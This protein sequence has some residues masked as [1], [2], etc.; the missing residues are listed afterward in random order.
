MAK[1]RDSAAG[2]GGH[3]FGGDWTTAKLDV[4]A[5]YLKA[6]TTAL[7]SQ[8]F[9]LEYIDAFAGTG[10]RDTRRDDNVSSPSCFF[11]NS[12]RRRHRI[13]SKAPCVAP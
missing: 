10:Y 9:L 7:K 3:A 6:Y 1:K 11:P 2:G 4:L 12:Q 8:P 5:G 13:I